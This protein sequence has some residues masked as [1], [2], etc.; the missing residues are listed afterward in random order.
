[1]SRYSIALV[2]MFSVLGCKKENLIQPEI[3]VPLKATSLSGYS[4]TSNDYLVINNLKSIANNFSDSKPLSP[5]NEFDNLSTLIN[6]TKIVGMGEAT[7]GTH[8]FFEM[9]HR[10]FRWLVQKHQFK[11]IAFESSWGYGLYVDRYVTEGIGN[12]STAMRKLQFGVWQTEEVRELIR[13]MKEYNSG[14]SQSDKIHFYGTDCQA[15]YDEI[16]LVN[17]Y[18]DK[19]DQKYKNTVNNVLKPLYDMDVVPEYRNKS[20]I[21]QATV[22]QNLDEIYT[23]F[24]A[25]KIEY[26]SKS[27]ENEFAMALQALRVIIQCEKFGSQQGSRDRFMAENTEWIMNY[28]GGDKKIAVW[29]HNA[30][31]SQIYERQGYFLKK[32]FKKAYQIFGFSL[33]KGDFSVRSYKY[34]NFQ[35]EPN[36]KLPTMSYG[37][38]NQIFLDS[39]IG[40]FYIKLSE[41]PADSPFEYWMQNS[42]KFF[43]AGA[44]YDESNPF[45]ENIIINKVYDVIFHFDN[46]KGSVAIR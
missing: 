6:T 33:G 3:I 25:N 9:K 2:F 24:K 41:I 28:S 14:K 42:P 5:Q 46:T 36:Q 34:N 7:H 31:V 26:V 13:W 15:W 16:S 1:M 27:S 37:S 23:T 21:Y 19:V 32:K 20:Q 39:N 22:S 35:D 38:Y 30:H 11:A 4:L 17:A 18:L 43:T 40:N 29:A 10:L 12:E 45:Y 8:E 44:L